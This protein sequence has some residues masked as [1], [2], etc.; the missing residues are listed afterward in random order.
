MF[1]DLSVPCGRALALGL[2]DGI[3]GP[4]GIV[5]DVTRCLDVVHLACDA[6]VAE[7]QGVVVAVERAPGAVP[8]AVGRFRIDPFDAFAARVAIAEDFGL[9]RLAPERVAD[10]F[11]AGA[12]NL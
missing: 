10:V 7:S 8:A 12:V 3:G 6:L 11:Y 9:G 5:A 4:A 2:E 1:D